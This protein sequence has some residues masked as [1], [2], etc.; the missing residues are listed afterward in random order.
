[1][2]K[3]TNALELSSELR[4]YLTEKDTSAL[5]KARLFEGFA[6]GQSISAERQEAVDKLAARIATLKGATR[7]PELFKKLSD[8][9]FDN[10]ANLQAMLFN[11]AQ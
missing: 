1:L 5:E 8:E 6:L 11:R 10:E 7:S 4:Q 3:I 2:P 9:V